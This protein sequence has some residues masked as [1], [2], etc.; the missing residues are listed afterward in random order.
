MLELFHEETATRETQPL[1]VLFGTAF[2][3][4]LLQVFRYSARHRQNLELFVCGNAVGPEAVAVGERQFLERQSVG[5]STDEAGT[6]E[7]V[8]FDPG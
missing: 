7:Q 6:A 1:D 8:L 2:W 5:D 3:I 4:D